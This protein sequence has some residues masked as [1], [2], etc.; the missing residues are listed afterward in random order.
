MSQK[1][2]VLYFSF[3][4]VIIGYLIFIHYF[5]YKI[6]IDAAIFNNILFNSLHGNIGFSSIEGINHFSMHFSPFLLILLPF[7]PLLSNYTLIIASYLSFLFS[8]IGV[9]FI[10]NQV[11]KNG[12]LSFLIGLTFICYAPFLHNIV[13]DFHEIIL[14]LPFFVFS[15]YLLMKNK[16]WLSLFLFMFTFLIKE[17]TFLLGIAFGLYMFFFHRKKQGLWLVVFSVL[18]FILVV[19]FIMPVLF[20]GGQSNLLWERYDYLGSSLSVILTKIL[21]EPF[22][23]FFPPFYMRKLIA[24]ICLFL[25][26]FFLPFMSLSVLFIPLVTIAYSYF[27]K[28][29]QLDYADHYA[30]PVIPYIFIAYIFAMEKLNIFLKNKKLIIYGLT[31][32]VLIFNMIFSLFSFYMRGSY[33]RLKPLDNKKAFF[34][35]VKLIPYDASVLTHSI[36]SFYCSDRKNIYVTYNFN[37][38]DVAKYDPDYILINFRVVFY[39]GGERT[40]ELDKRANNLK[41]IV[42]NSK[43]KPIFF[44]ND[45][46]LLSR[47]T[48]SNN[49]MKSNLSLFKEYDFNKYKNSNYLNFVPGFIKQIATKQ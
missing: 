9:Y 49:D 19:K 6:S 14:A 40:N 10:V 44:E 46:L 15:F 48:L 3:Y 36:S 26:L 4:A 43:Y 24:L 31:F 45:V 11:S 21:R 39:D 37:P 13:W 16:V 1:A 27:S 5:S 29:P 47:Q 41:K 30:L 38:A 2:K 12:K 18:G 35:V 32:F 34:S 22:S 20:G 33:E 25:P 28:L 8:V 23:V 7:Y 42:F 17:E